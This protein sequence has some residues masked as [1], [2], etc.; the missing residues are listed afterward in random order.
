MIHTTSDPTPLH[1]TSASQLRAVSMWIGVIG[2]LFWV[3][4][5]IAVTTVDPWQVLKQILVGAITPSFGSE[6]TTFNTLSTAL[7]NT[8]SFAL[9]GVVSG[10]LGGCALTLVFQYKMVRIFSAFIRSIHE[11]FWALIFIQILG[12]SPLTGILAIA[13]PFSGTFA[14]VYF[15]LIDETDPAPMSAIPINTDSLSRWFYGRV[16]QAWTHL[17]SYS[18]YRTECAL[19]SS[20]VLGFIGLPTIGYHLETAFRQG[21]Y[22]EAA[23]LLYLFFFII[24]TLRW[25][26]KA[27][28]LPFYLLAS[29]LWLKPFSESHFSAD[30]LIR[31]I[32]IDIVPAPLR[33]ATIN[34]TGNS[35]IDNE[36]LSWW[37]DKVFYQSAF[38]GVIE[39]LGIGLIALATT[40]LV[41]LIL[42]PLASR[43]FFKT[44]YLQANYLFL[45]ISRSTPEYVLA[46]IALLL[47]GPSW[48]PAIFALSL[49]NGAIIAFLLGQTSNAISL[50]QDSSTGINRYWYEIL[51]RLYRQFLALLFYR[52]EIILRETAILGILGI[53]T[54]GFYI[55]SA[56]ESLRLDQAFI[57]ILI[58][59]SLN[60]GADQL[61]VSI[62][63]RLKLKSTPEEH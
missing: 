15:E 52:W 60:I 51:P 24:M 42:L 56:F 31:L 44:P 37:I 10:A 6:L 5:D 50:R 55:D 57:L 49:H 8:I 2:L 45:M 39:T 32:T 62:R 17:V 14:R 23:G 40:G 43:Q 22:S 30:A 41:T 7:L 34:S 9:L 33:S 38:P 18:F 12:L 58:T 36:Y 54:L 61:S 46:F 16:T 11:I 4:G 13:I 48:L 1:N 25:W 29:V 19:R 20:A 26:L 27:P 35:T 28:L 59:A 47:L 21:D 63:H 3:L 53:H